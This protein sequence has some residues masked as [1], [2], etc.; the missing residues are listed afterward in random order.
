MRHGIVEG[1]PGIFPDPISRV[2]RKIGGFF[3]RRRQDEPEPEASPG[4]EPTSEPTRP[5]S[6]ASEPAESAESSEA[7]SS[8]SEPSD[9]PKSSDDDGGPATGP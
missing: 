5:T 8:E 3:D 2:M 7:S 4:A 6:E 1:E 9:P